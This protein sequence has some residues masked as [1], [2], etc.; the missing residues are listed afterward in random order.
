MLNLEA[1]KTVREVVLEHP[2]VTRLFEKVGIDYCC[3][4]QRSLAEACA[5]ANITPE[6]LL[7][8]L[9]STQ[10]ASEVNGD[11]DF[12]KAKLTDLTSCFRAR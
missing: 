4:G 9:E 10:K 5:A 12:R 8:S 1:N 2:G 7:N 3:G 11:K 6:E